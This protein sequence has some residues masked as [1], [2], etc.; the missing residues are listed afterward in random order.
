MT[1]KK[2]LQLPLVKRVFR[3]LDYYNIT[4]FIQKDFV[5]INY[6]DISFSWNFDS[7]S[8]GLNFIR[9]ILLKEYGYE[10]KYKSK[11]I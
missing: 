6:R 11:F 2:F 8:A 9:R 4:Y 7:Y 1:F 10:F 3:L 5:L